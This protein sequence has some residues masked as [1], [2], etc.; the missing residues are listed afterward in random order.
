MTTPV[1]ENHEAN[2]TV[3]VVFSEGKSSLGLAVGL[4]ILF[5]ALL[6]V[7]IAAIFWFRRRQAVDIEVSNKLQSQ[8]KSHDAKARESP[9]S[10]YAGGL[11]PPPL[12]PIYEN[13]QRG[14]SAPHELQRSAIQS[15]DIHR[16]H[17][18][19]LQCD[20]NEAIYSNDPALYQPN[21]EY[22]EDLYIV[23]DV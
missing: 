17:D 12:S 11:Q 7:G 8:D 2:S 19:Y 15:E 6:I 14:Q 9:Y 18:V 21:P 22:S 4:P 3:T 1:N 16:P 10:G 23:P 20:S 13:F 5:V